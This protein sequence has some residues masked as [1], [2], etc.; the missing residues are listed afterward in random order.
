MSSV[1]GMGGNFG[2]EALAVAMTKKAN[3]QSGQAAL[4]LVE[5]A[6]QS[7]QQVNA[8]A[9]SGSVGRNINIRV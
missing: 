6:V 4:S 2:M 5:A 1:A 7:T 9:Q 8:L 3:E